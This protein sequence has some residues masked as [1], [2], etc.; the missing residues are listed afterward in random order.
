MPASSLSGAGGGLAGKPTTVRRT[1]LA[2]LVVRGLRAVVDA[3]ASSVSADAGRWTIEGVGDGERLMP[4]VGARLE[5]RVG[6]VILVMLIFEF[7]FDG[8]A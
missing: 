1:C 8:E 3:G 7:D 5:E 2:L 6:G 4:G